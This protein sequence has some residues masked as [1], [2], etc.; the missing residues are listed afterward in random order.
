MAYE[1]YYAFTTTSTV[2]EKLCFLMWFAMDAGYVAVAVAYAYSPQRRQV[3]IQRTFCGTVVGVA[4][5]HTLCKYFPDER[6]QLTAYWAGVILELPAGW[7]M[8]YALL[9]R[10][11]TKGQ[12][13]ETWW[14]FAP[15]WNQQ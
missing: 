11:D 6:E 9:K 8:I 1:V 12:S 14:V 13:L 15:F 4:F 10:G 7:A 5:L 2:F 3:V